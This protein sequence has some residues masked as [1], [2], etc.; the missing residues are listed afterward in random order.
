MFLFFLRVLKQGNVP[1]KSVV[2]YDFKEGKYT[3]FRNYVFN[4]GAVITIH[5]TKENYSL[6]SKFYDLD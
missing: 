3:H 5:I 6:I 2:E 1:L 4:Q